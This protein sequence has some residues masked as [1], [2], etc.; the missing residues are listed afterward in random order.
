MTGSPGTRPRLGP[1]HRPI[2]LTPLLVL[3]L[4]LSV[5]VALPGATAHAAEPIT[6][7]IPER[8][9][10][11]GIGL[12]VEEFAA[13]PK[14][15]PPDG[16]VTDPR[17][18]RHAR[19]NYLSE[20][21]D[22]SGRMAVPDLNGK[23][24]LVENGTPRVYLDVAG[25]FSPRSSA[26]RVSAWASGSPPSTRASRRTAASTPSTPSW[27]PPPPSCPTCGRRRTRCTTASSPSGRPTTPRADTF[28]G[29]R[30]EVLRIG[31]TGRVHGIQ[32]IDFNP[33]ARP[34][35]KDYGLL[36]LAVGDG[37]QGA[38]NG[39]PQSLAVPHGKILRIDPRGSDS[40]NGKYGIPSRNP[41][42]GT[43]GA[44]GEI[45][46][47]GM[48]DP[49]RFSWD[50]G[51]RNRMYLGHI[52]EHAIEAVYEVRAGD[53]LGWSEREGAFVFDKAA[54]DPCAKIQPLPADDEKYGYTYPVAAYD[55]DP[56]A[57]WN[58]TSDVGRAIVGG[59]VLAT[60]TCPSCTASTSSATSSTAGSSTPTPRTCAG[61]ARTWPSCTT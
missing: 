39:E 16:P 44:L 29:T 38:R 47:Y 45:Y 60:A 18:M 34:H 8:P 17:L 36:Y 57:N 12:T 24:Y 23:L 40:A 10:T 51:G 6:D 41:F 56:P 14:S 5:L 22:G 21:P 15:V 4:L 50:S 55:H 59:F 35:D 9:T 1:S 25:T 3:A 28:K 52:G 48:R 54:T 46:A 37:G 33:T 32:Q 2:V 30:R 19:I 27:P 43:P 58:C 11:S 42:V 26:A 31:F 20:L 7:P 61:A 53:N 49:H 13:F